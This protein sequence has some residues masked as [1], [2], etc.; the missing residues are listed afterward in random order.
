MIE[1]LRGMLALYLIMVMIG[2]GIFAGLMLIALL[3]SMVL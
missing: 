3:G 1:V 2:F